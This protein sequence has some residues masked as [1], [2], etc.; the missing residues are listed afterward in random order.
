MA[1]KV[2]LVQYGS[3]PE[4]CFPGDDL[5][6]HKGRCQGQEG[7]IGNDGSMLK[8]GTKTRTAEQIA[9][10]APIWAEA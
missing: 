8:E 2:T 5:F 7:R 10:E 9:L 3:I 4:G 1:M 6:G